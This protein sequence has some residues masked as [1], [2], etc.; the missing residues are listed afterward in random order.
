MHETGNYP[1]VRG[2]AVQTS[3][4]LQKHSAGKTWL[5]LLGEYIEGF[6]IIAKK[7]DQY[8]AEL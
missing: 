1:R 4:P 8:V 6:L 2:A 5:W 3:L 7:R